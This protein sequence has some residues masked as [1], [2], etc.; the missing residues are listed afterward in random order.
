MSSHKPPGRLTRFPPSSCNIHPCSVT[1]RY[2]AMEVTATVEPFDNGRRF[3]LRVL[4]ARTPPPAV[5]DRGAT[6]PDS[7]FRENPPGGGSFVRGRRW[8]VPYSPLR[9]AARGQGRLGH[10]QN[11]S[12]QAS[13]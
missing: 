8:L 1:V 3:S 2:H 9:G 12:P 5:C 13:C 4:R 10:G 6:K 7:L 11:P